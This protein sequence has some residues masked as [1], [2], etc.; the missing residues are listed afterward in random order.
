MHAPICQRSIAFRY[1][2][3]DSALLSVKR[4]HTMGGKQYHRLCCVD[5][6]TNSCLTTFHTLCIQWI[7]KLPCLLYSMMH[8]RFLLNCHQNFAGKITK[9]MLISIEKIL[10]WKICD[11]SGTSLSAA[12]W[13]NEHPIC[14]KRWP[15]GVFSFSYFLQ[16]FV[17]SVFFCIF[18]TFC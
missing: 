11:N 2:C 9:I 8:S 10:T 16:R 18:V 1:T 3:A 14:A 4:S 5:I 15:G 17:V 13:W 7:I 6:N 12:S